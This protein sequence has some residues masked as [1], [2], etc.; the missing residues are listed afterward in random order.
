ML[1]QFCKSLSS[2]L[3]EE[4]DMPSEVTQYQ[5]PAQDP[6]NTITEDPVSTT[7]SNGKQNFNHQHG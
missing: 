2:L 1:Y 5:V 6:L 4:L 3:A 7:N